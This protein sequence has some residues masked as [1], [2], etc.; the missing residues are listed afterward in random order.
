MYSSVVC[1]LVKKIGH[2]LCCTKEILHFS[3]KIGDG[4]IEFQN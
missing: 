3:D 4:C 1:Q 2:V